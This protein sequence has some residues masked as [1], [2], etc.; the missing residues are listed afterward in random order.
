MMRVRG[1]NFFLAKFIVALHA[2]AVPFRFFRDLPVRI[3][4]MER[5]VRDFSCVI[6]NNVAARFSRDAGE[7]GRGIEEMSQPSKNDPATSTRMPL[8]TL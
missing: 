2:T 1:E 8:E 7:R 4:L 3:A 6:P 5:V